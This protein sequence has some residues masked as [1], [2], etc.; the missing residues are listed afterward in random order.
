LA[1]RLRRKADW[2]DP[3]RVCRRSRRHHATDVRLDSSR[4]PRKRGLALRSP[5]GAHGRTSSQRNREILRDGY[6]HRCQ[7]VRQRLGKDAPLRRSVQRSG[8]IIVTPILSGLHHR[9]ARI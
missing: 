3:T 2:I 8:T 5:G 4:T 9:Y 1:E 6:H 7:R